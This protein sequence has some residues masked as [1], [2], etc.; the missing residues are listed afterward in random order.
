ML[1]DTIPAVELAEL[2]I[3]RAM[4]ARNDEYYQRTAPR[5]R[6]IDDLQLEMMRNNIV[7]PRDVL[8]ECPVTGFMSIDGYMAQRRIHTT[9]LQVAPQIKAVAALTTAVHEQNSYA[10]RG[11]D[12]FGTPSGNKQRRD[13]LAVARAA[14]LTYG[15]PKEDEPEEPFWRI[16]ALAYALLIGYKLYRSQ[17]LAN[18]FHDC[19]KDVYA[20]RILRPA[21][22]AD[23]HRVVFGIVKLFR[24][25]VGSELAVAMLFPGQPLTELTVAELMWWLWRA[26][27]PE[28]VPDQNSETYNSKLR[29]YHIFCSK[30][31]G[32]RLARAYDDADIPFEE[33]TDAAMQSGVGMAVAG[34]LLN[35]VRMGI[36]PTTI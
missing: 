13:L 8:Q 14:E 20:N 32:V 7:V 34:H 27:P 18:R 12:E 5:Q 25:D 35:C 3:D 17:T 30:F 16:V 23:T 4:F 11:F 9:F 22:C 15:W 2:S 6:E 29:A 36:L 26:E 10:M 31:V 21:G 19:Y 33:L 24:G 1:V 28:P